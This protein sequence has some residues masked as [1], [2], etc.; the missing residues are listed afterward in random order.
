[1]SILLEYPRVIA[2]GLVSEL[3]GAVWIRKIIN[4]DF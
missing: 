2:V 1:M 3:I 4:F